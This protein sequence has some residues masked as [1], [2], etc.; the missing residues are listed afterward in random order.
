MPAGT[1]LYVADILQGAPQEWWGADYVVCSG[2]F[3]VK[4]QVEP[5]EWRRF[6]NAMLR[7]MFELAKVGIGFNLMTSYVDY[8]APHLCYLPPADMLDFC[9]RHL[10]RRVVIRHEYPLWEY[11]VYV[12][13]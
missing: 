10:S 3:H 1:P 8:E 13:R 2:V 7:R 6:I 11:T 9:V 4:D 12:Y 5:G